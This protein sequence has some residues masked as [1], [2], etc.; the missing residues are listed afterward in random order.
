MS[1]VKDRFKGVPILALTATVTEKVKQ[2]IIRK[3]GI[4][5]CY[6]FQS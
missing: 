4:E 1:T 3:L 6:Y 2:D 5:R